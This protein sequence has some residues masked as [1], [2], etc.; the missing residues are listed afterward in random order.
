MQKGTHAQTRKKTKH[1][2][3][4]ATLREPLKVEE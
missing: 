1:Y 2:L 4:I 3:D